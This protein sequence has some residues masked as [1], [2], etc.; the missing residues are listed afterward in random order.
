MK[1]YHYTDIM[2]EEVQEEVQGQVNIRWLITKEMG[3]NHFA[4]RMFEVKPGSQAG[5]HSHSWEH[6]VYILAGTGVFSNGKEEVEAGPGSVVF[7]PGNEPHQLKNT[8]HELM[9]YICLVPYL[10]E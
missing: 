7:I 1:G 3:A 8:G 2:P 6:E 5:P 9:R 10:D 4:M